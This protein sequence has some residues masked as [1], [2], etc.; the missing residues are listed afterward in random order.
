[1]HHSLYKYYSERKWAEAF[2]KGEVLFRS[3]S[4]FRDLEDGQVRGDQNEGTSVFRPNGGLVITNQT[5]GWTRVL[6]GAFKSAANFADIFVFC[7]SRSLNQ[8][9]WSE[10]RASVCIEITNI[11]EFCSRMEA[12]LP[13]SAAFPGKPGRTRIGQSVEYYNETE[14]C[15][16]R[17]ALPDLI[18]ASKQQ[19]YSWQDEYRLV[20]SLTDALDFEKIEARLVGENAH[21]PAR[22]AEHRQYL[23]KAGR[24]DDI[25]RVHDSE[26][27]A[28]SASASL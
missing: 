16:P 15:N 26:P 3:L 25:C 7:L 23:L 13:P 1:M 9:L 8:R 11:K 12:A 24:L 20:F 18:A 5:Q 14:N 2:L 28:Y 6:K 21:D 27:A 17:W 4:Y 19:S 10:F 22:P